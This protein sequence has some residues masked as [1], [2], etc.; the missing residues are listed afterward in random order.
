MRKPKTG[1]AGFSFYK[2]KGL[3]K[4]LLIHLSK[5]THQK[6]RRRA[7]MDELSIQKTVR[8]IIEE[9]VRNEHNA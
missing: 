9:A 1:K 7:F 8:R 6:L 2:R 5:E 3:E 4:A